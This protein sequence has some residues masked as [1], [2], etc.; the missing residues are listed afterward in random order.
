MHSAHFN[1]ELKF[2]PARK[3]KTIDGQTYFGRVLISLPICVIMGL[4]R[5]VWANVEECMALALQYKKN[6]VWNK[7]Q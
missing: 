3:R 4:D 6:I 1:K 7:M 2:L 5:R